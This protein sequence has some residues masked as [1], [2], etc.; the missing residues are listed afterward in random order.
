M[1]KPIR[2]GGLLLLSTA[3]TATAA[4]AQDASPA[5]EA[6][7][8]DPAPAAGAPPASED[9]IEVS[10]PGADPGQT[11][12]IVV[13]GRNIPNVLR[14]TAE[15]VSVLSADDI[16]RTGEGDIAGA[17]QRVTG[18]SVVGSGFVYVRGLGD[19]Y[20]LALLNGSPLPS[21]EPLRRVVPLDIFPTGL[22]AS[23]LVQKS[24]SVNYP[25]EFG[26]GVINL[27]TTSIPDESFLTLGGSAELDGETTGHFGY[28]YYGGDLDPLGFDDGSRD[29]PAGLR[30]AVAGGDFNGATTAG[31]RRDF[32]AALTNAP[33]TLL[34]RV[35]NLPPN[36]G[37]N[38]SAGTAF[39]LLGARIGLL[40]AVGYSNSWRTRDALQQ[41]S[42]DPKLAGIPQSSFRRVTTDNRILANATV[43]LGAEIGRHKLRWTNIFIRDTLKQGRLAAGFNR[44]VQ[45]QDPN[46]PPSIIEQN[47]YWFE[48]QL[49]DTQFVGEFKF[50]DLSVDLRGTYGNTRRESPYE[51]DI[52]YTY[53]GDG[54]PATK[55]VSDVDDYVNNLTSGGQSST[56]AFNHLEEDVYAG[57]IDLAHRLNGPM[58]TTLSAGYAYTKSRRD[59]SRYQF[60]YF[61]P[62][63]ALPIAVAQERPDYLL[64]DFNIHNFN[65]QLRDISG[66]EGAAAYEAGLRIHAGY[67]QAEIELPGP[68][69]RAQF[70]VRYEEAV[71]T[72]LTSAAGAAP[73]RI[74]NDY[75]LP[76]ATVTWNFADNMQLRLHGSKTI[77]RPQFR[78]LAPQIYQ[79]FESDR[80]F[81]GNPFLTDT[82]LT[83]AEARYE[84]YFRRGERFSLAGF[85]KKIDNPIESAAFFAGGGQLRTGF[86]N[87]PQATLYGA[88]AELQTF[89]PL[90]GLGERFANRRLLLVAN[91][92]YTRSR[93]K[94][95]GSQVIGPDLQPVAAD[96]LFEDGAPLTGQSDHLANIQ[97][98]IENTDRLAQATFLLT[99][100]SERVTER[101]PIQG[102]LRQPD[103]VEKPGL[104]LDF[105][106][107]EQIRFIGKSAEIKLEARNLLGQDYEE[108][109][110]FE[111]NRIEVNSY[112]VGRTISAGLSVTF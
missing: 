42:L 79:D 64:S 58:P 46:L 23:S 45:D 12:D 61:R 17:L 2:L 15:V 54:N 102:S 83:N 84:Y 101:G 66:A 8:P 68:A 5:Q 35:R 29:M 93:V 103:I 76:A 52:S 48:R 89:L 21:P 107:R 4:F 37:G 106:A 57:G 60:Q 85:Y 82:K 97:F 98:G 59:S 28:S 9:D 86:A 44:S 51:R 65:I 22:I 109:Q 71:E 55:G 91:Y 25:G 108:F 3:L 112:K 49:A 74:A 110:Q 38:V 6:L 16:A 90:S 56:I 31:Q 92:T 18:L 62:E 80:E 40:A 26:G 30:G 14:N 73:T 105:V 50:G 100:A 7:E 39:D 96:L 88:E 67:A 77:A 75:W 13:T 111:G 70:G 99:Y 32:A 81:T 33:T 43:G 47:T 19:R 95:D 72:V 69:L 41:I 1:L 78:E 63:G 11:G 34:Q 20:S 27:T 87:A 53:L 24:Y 94:A 10:A 104:R 36:L